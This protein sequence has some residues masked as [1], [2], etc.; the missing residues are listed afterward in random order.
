MYG[1][2]LLGAPREHHQAFEQA[3]CWLENVG[4]AE[5]GDEIF[6]IQ[7]AVGGGKYTGAAAFATGRVDELP[8]DCIYHDVNTETGSSGS[9]VVKLDGSLIGLHR[10]S[11][12]KNRNKATNFRHILAKLLGGT[13]MCDNSI[14]KSLEESEE[15][16][17]NS[18][19][20]ESIIKV[21]VIIE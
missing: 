1:C 14:E 16:N 17:V 8:G 12:D 18:T 9:P 21:Y 10:A 11:Y 15:G 4:I 19:V 13:P 7:H 5:V 6:I 20:I 3:W 2:H